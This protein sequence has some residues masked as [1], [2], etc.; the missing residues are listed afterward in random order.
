MPQTSLLDG[1]EWR[2]FRLFLVDLDDGE[3]DR[4]DR[5]HRREVASRQTYESDFT[6][7]FFSSLQA[8]D[9]QIAQDTIRAERR[10]RTRD[11][12]MLRQMAIPKRTIPPAAR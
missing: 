4:T 9:L 1:A 6:R 8:A 7:L 3:L 10:A 2:A 11:R 5:E 12:R